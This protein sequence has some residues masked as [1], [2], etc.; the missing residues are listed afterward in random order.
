MD[1]RLQERAE[2][3]KTLLNYK[4]GHNVCLH[5]NWL[6]AVLMLCYYGTWDMCMAHHALAW[7]NL[8]FEGSIFPLTSQDKEYPE[9]A[10]QIARL[11]RQKEILE[12]TFKVLFNR[13]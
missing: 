1:N 7:N 8:W 9:K 5:A 13:L 4:V 2:E 11:K 10:L 3:V 12:A 6:N